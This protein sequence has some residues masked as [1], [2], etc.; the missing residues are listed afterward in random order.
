MDFC[1]GK[2]GPGVA[3]SPG[4]QQLF[5]S[6]CIEIYSDC[7][8]AKQIHINDFRILEDMS[9]SARELHPCQLKAF[10]LQHTTNDT[11]IMRCK[12][13]DLAHFG[14]VHISCIRETRVLTG[15]PGHTSKTQ[16]TPNCPVS[17][18][19]KQ[20]S[21]EFSFDLSWQWC[22]SLATINEEP[23]LSLHPET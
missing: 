10:G 12:W 11:I 5:I 17:R 16:C 7:H 14:A 8:K 23:K 21:C 6:G 9:E 20:Y 18:Q 19:I 15:A 1:Q 2:E 4:S 22:A 3:G 13:A